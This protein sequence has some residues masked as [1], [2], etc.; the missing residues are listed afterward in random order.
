MK[1]LFYFIILITFLS[2]CLDNETEEIVVF[3]DVRSLD[4]RDSEHELQDYEIDF[5]DF[6]YIFSATIESRNYE[7][8]NGFIHQ[9]YGCY[10]IQSSGAITSIVNVY[11][12]GE[13]SS[14]EVSE[15]FFDLSFKEIDHVL[16]FDSLP[17]FDC[18]KNIYDKTGCFASRS[19]SLADSEI[20]KKSQLAKDDIEIIQSMVDSV[21]I[22]VVNTYNYVYHFSKIEGKWYV[23][24]IDLRMHCTV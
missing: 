2:S 1:K 5:A 3:E 9:G 11:D 17:N 16:S 6:Y 14:E 24:F 22:C 20:W 15:R 18:T 21:N 7:I 13:F 8:F 19:N 4:D 23:V 12:V 10:V